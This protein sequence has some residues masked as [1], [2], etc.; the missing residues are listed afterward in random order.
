MKKFVFVVGLVL[1]LGAC[2]RKAAERA[3]R[4]P[5]QIVKQ[6]VTL[7]AAAKEAGDKQKLEDLCA[8]KLHEAFDRM[9]DEAFR[10]SYLGNNLRISDLSVVDSSVNKD[11][12]TATVHYKVTVENKQGTDPTHEINEREV[13]LVHEK[14]GWYIDTI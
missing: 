11:R 3:S 14:A 2:N 1:V 12:D 6:F 4:T 5:E 8:G 10:I 9:T 13:T 7:S